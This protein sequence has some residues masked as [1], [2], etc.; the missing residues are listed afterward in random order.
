MQT[1]RRIEKNLENLVTV[2]PQNTETF[3]EIRVWSYSG[4][5]LYVRPYP[6]GTVVDEGLEFYST[7]TN[8]NLRQGACLCVNMN[9]WAWNMFA[10]VRPAEPPRH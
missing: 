1:G 6:T 10:I 7:R 5:S 4:Q 2:V 8:N 3:S 9:F